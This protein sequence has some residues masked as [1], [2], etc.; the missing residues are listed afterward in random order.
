LPLGGA[1]EEPTLADVMSRAGEYVANLHRQL[2]SIVAEETYEQQTRSL[3]RSQSPVE[4]R[5]KL[6]SDLLL[7]RPAGADRYV[8]FRD[9]FAVDGAPVRDRGERLTRLFM[10]P[11]ATSSQQVKAIIDESARHNIGDIPRNIN[12]P[13]L[14]LFFLQPETQRLFRFRRAKNG[15]PELAV[16]SPMPGGDTVTFRITTEVWVVEFKETGRPTIIKTHRGR[17]FPAEGRFWIE[18]DTGIVRMSEL[19][20]ENHEV[21]AT[22]AVSY[23]SEPLLG[24]L[25]PVEMRERYRARSSRIEG[26]ATYGRFRQ[27]QVSTSETIGKPPGE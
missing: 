17:D 21:N 5:K 26:V 23:Q 10:Q 19:V 24:F 1:A 11:T 15:R 13:M 4:Q 6:Q 2:S 25:V 9:V 18:P 7:V 8:E 20:M 27:F 16:S 3:A 14:P 12:T 22:I